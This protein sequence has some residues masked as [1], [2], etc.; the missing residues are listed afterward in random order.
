M[1]ELSIGL[2]AVLAAVVFYL[3]YVVFQLASGATVSVSPEALQLILNHRDEFFDRLFA[4]AA[5]TRNQVDDFIVKILAASV[6]KEIK[7]ED[8]LEQFP[9]PYMGNDE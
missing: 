8:V 4:E 7:A 5:K 6:P 9:L 1:L 2:N 3:I